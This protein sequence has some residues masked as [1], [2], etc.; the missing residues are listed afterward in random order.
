MS[1]NKKNR[2]VMVNSNELTETIK[3]FRIYLFDCFRIL[4]DK[5]HYGT[6]NIHQLGTF[7]LSGVFKSLFS[8]RLVIDE[9][10]TRLAP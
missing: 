3:K 6:L 10:S 2:K 4:R 1:K 5:M 9:V 8:S 7:A